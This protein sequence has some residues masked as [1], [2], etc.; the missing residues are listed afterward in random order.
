MMEALHDC[1][2][3][4][5]RATFQTQWNKIVG[6]VGDHEMDRG[7][8]PYRQVSELARLSHKTKSSSLQGAVP[9]E[10]R[11]LI[12]ERRFKTRPILISRRRSIDCP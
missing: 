4:Q 8:Q 9:E 6:I 2:I 7:S 10:W 1:F 11:Q 5:A 12:S 3:N